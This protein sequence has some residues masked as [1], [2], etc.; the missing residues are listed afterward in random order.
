M[1][2]KKPKRLRKS[3]RRKKTAY[4]DRFYQ[5]RNASKTNE[6]S[7]QN[8]PCKRK[9]TLRSA[10]RK[11]PLWRL[12]PL[13]KIL[14]FPFRRKNLFT[15]SA[16]IICLISFAGFFYLRQSRPIEIRAEL[17]GLG[18]IE[19]TY[20]G[21]QNAGIS[22]LCGCYAEQPSEAWRGITFPARYVQIQREGSKPLT[23]Y[24]MTAAEPGSTQW[25]GSTFQLQ[26]SVYRFA[27]PETEDFD[28]RV[29]LNDKFPESYRVISTR[30]YDQTKYFMLISSKGLNVALMGNTALGSW[31]PTD[32][33]QVRVEYRKEGMH[34]SARNIAV[35]EERY[36][37]TEV[38]VETGTVPEGVPL[39]DFLGPD[40]IFW[41][42]D[43]AA[44]LVANEDIIELTEPPQKHEK[45]I[46]AIITQPSF[47]VRLGVDPME[48]DL[49]DSFVRD[50]KDYNSLPNQERE[51]GS[52]VGAMVIGQLDDGKVTVSI[53]DPEKQ[54]EEFD[55]VYGLMKEN[56]VVQRRVNFDAMLDGKPFKKSY[57]MDFRYP[58]IPP[59]RGFN[60]FGPISS[61][62]FSKAL[63]TL[64][65]GSRDIEIKVPS[66]LDFREIQSLDVDKG[67]FAVPIQ[68][69]P[70]EAK[71]KIQL[72]ATSQTFLNN[73]PLNRVID[74]LKMTNF[75][76]SLISIIVGVLSLAVGLW[77]L[78]RK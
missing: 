5:I 27:I 71:A 69:N 35:I 29:L 7:P 20:S 21:K 51:K 70:A 34:L 41:S 6:S 2:K 46:Q 52:S 32:A 78:I 73:E 36:R 38:N 56:D 8:D 77:S 75:E 26:G 68:L 30:K 59:N 19:F 25:W 37:N 57:M 23:G 42:E 11:Y 13:V 31:I 63:G 28:P 39:G 47:S 43:P 67:V 72:K 44:V 14:I 40:V 3:A 24:M 17:T 18:D 48:Q 53:I 76:L 4:V 65:L 1:H 49:V 74:E 54:S 12:T 45:V 10:R 60:I 66:M 22:P 58:P 16:A 9:E 64:A 50:L 55:A 61:I 33:S 62:K 15:S